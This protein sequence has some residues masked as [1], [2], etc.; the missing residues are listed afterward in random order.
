MECVKRAVM[1]EL[2][3]RPALDAEE[4]AFSARLNPSADPGKKWKRSCLSEPQQYAQ[5]RKKRGLSAGRLQSNLIS[6]RPVLNSLPTMC[7][8]CVCE[9]CV[10]V[11]DQW[12]WR[13]TACCAELPGHPLYHWRRS[14][15]LSTVVLECRP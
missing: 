12:Q 6:R 15:S 1:I 9:V 7:V 5:Q 14:Q 4:M 3:Y 11:A 2:T 8:K 13:Y 10:C